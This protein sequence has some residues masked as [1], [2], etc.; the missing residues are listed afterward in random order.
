M[1]RQS[2]ASPPLR[3]LTPVAS[4]RL[5]ASHQKDRAGGG[6]RRE[7][8][9][10]NCGRRPCTDPKAHSA[11]IIKLAMVQLYQELRAFR[12]ARPDL[13]QVH[14]ELV[15]ERP[16]TPSTAVSGHELKRVMENAVR[17]AFPCG[18]HRLG[19]NWMRQK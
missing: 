13:L 16:P 14:D 12:A 6:R 4:G 17:L 7:W 19:A 5:K 10:S 11:D 8:K 15:L 1:W 9:L 3:L 18:G 2:G